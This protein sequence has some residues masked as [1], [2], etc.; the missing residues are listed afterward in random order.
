[1]ISK[2]AYLAMR[3]SLPFGIKTRFK[4]AFIRS[5]TKVQRGT[6]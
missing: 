6:K 3:E 4:L 1:M 2:K 5:Y